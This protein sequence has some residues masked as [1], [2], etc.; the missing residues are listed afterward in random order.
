MHCY[1]A[2]RLF[3]L[4]CLANQLPPLSPK[5]GSRKCLSLVCLV[6][7]DCPDFPDYW[8][9]KFHFRSFNCH[10]PTFNFHRPTKSHALS[11]RDKSKHYQYQYTQPEAEARRLS[12][13]TP[14]YITLA[15]F[16]KEI[17]EYGGG[18]SISCSLDDLLHC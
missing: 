11:L 17:V 18:G 4:T 13:S 14:I 1:L 8:P 2:R 9:K 12:I 10:W 16:Y 5:G 15:N 6:C 7:L 3:T